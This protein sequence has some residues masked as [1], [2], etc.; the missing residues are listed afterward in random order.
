MKYA[1]AA[2][3]ALTIAC[4][5][6]EDTRAPEPSPTPQDSQHAGINTPHGDHSPPG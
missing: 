2:M 1:V 3:A 4:S 5:S 6:P